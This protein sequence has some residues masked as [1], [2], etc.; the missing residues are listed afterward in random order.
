MSGVDEGAVLR[1][2]DRILTGGTSAG[3]GDGALLDRFV[4]RRDEAAFA[5]L[6]ERH[7]PLVLGV[8][9]RLL[10][11]PYAVD[12]AF[13]A[14][15]LV[16]VKK[17]ASIRDGDRLGPWL[18]GVAVRVATRAR[19]VT[20][21]RL[22]REIPGAEETAVA[23]E[24]RDDEAFGPDLRAVLDAELARLPGRFRD[25]LVLCYLQGQTHEEAARRLRC[26]VGTVRSRLA[27]GRDRLRSRLA[28]HGLAPAAGALVAALAVESASASVLRPSVPETLVE[29]TTRAAMQ[30]AA[31][32]A[33][34]SATA[35]ALTQGML[36]SMKIQQGKWLAAG[37]AS[38]GLIGGA[39][40]IA[41]QGPG[42][43][44]VATSPSAKAVDNPIPEKLEVDSRD[45][46][47]AGRPAKK[48]TTAGLRPKEVRFITSVAPATAKPGEVVFY[49][50]TAIVDPDWHIYRADKGQAAAG[51]APIATR[52][53]FFDKGS[54]QV[55][56]EW[57]T[58]TEAIK[59]KEPAFPDL[60]FVEF[61]EDTVT[62]SIRL[63]V[64][65]NAKA[66]DAVLRSQIYFQ[67][68]DAKSCKPPARVT[69]PDAKVT[70]R[71]TVAAASGP[72]ATPFGAAVSPNATGGAFGVAAG[73][74]NGFPPRI[75][76]RIQSEK[77]V[78]TL[79]PARDR[80]AT[81]GTNSASWET[82]EA[83]KGTTVIPVGGMS[84]IAVRYDGPEIGE[85]AAFD[86][87]KAKW[88]RNPLVEPAKGQAFPIVFLDVVVYRIGRRVY[89]FSTQSDKWD[90][91]TLDEG[92][93]A[94]PNI[95]RNFV[96]VEDADHLWVFNGKLGRWTEGVSLGGR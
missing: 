67:I 48:D 68:C 83:P 52:F 32:G 72:F 14:T 13:Q 6:V 50:V 22:A 59:K 18:Y 42:G 8:C 23:A 92:S 55:E 65:P 29:S 57:E 31:G 96:T 89:A 15:F 62:W 86:A 25:P 85:I 4:A 88:F 71:P 27:R 44:P 82:Y 66:G 64:P 95:A 20:I 63:R 76:S 75:Q 5:A 45:T 40:V 17:A 46:P 70:I 30:F 84:L 87:D 11:D 80:I 39:G 2:L 1:Q 16:L 41:A 60:P 51:D 37:V 12:D 21:R 28:R 90:V 36:T 19:G 10:R 61:Y 43:D 81:I 49:S 69:V 79:T 47:A 7:G 56:G 94:Q 9:R 78:A 74:A 91:L 34:A 38:L 93:N 33:V 24:L 58:T 26:P 73:P 35:C 3:L 77:Y 54:L 53:D